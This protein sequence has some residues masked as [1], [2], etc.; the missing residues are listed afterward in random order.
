VSSPWQAFFDAHAPR[1]HENAFTQNT[2]AEV[3]FLEELFEALPGSSVLDLGCGTGRH[4]VRFAEQG[5]RVTGVDLSAGMLSEARKAAG[6]RLTEE[7]PGPG[8]VRLI[9]AD[10]RRWEPDLLYDAVICLCEGGLGL[11]GPQDDPIASD[12]SILKTAYQ[13]LRPNGMFV[14]TAMNGYAFIRQISDELT[15]AGRFDPATMLAMYEDE[16]ELPEGKT[17]MQ[18]R[19]RLFIPPEMV[20]LM[21]HC[22]FEVRAV[23]GGTAG[24]WGRRALKLDE[25]EAMYVCAKT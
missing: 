2:R 10:A 23:W 1:Y 22:G 11:I 12:L 20:A 16:W 3:E 5:W 6:D 19:E 9:Q 18:I 21:R 25:V 15:A 8:H 17:M 24:D 14:A 13:A 4:A 7:I